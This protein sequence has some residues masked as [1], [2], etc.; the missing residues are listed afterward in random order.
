MGDFSS[1][2]YSKTFVNG[3]TEVQINESRT[4]LTTLTTVY[5]SSFRFSLVN[6]LKEKILY[7]PLNK[8]EKGT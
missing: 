1:K 8:P 2:F 5:S 6:A 4:C 7:Q 3:K